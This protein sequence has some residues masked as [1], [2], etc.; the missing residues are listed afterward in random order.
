MVSKRERL[1][2]VG[3]VAQVL[4]VTVSAVRRWLLESKLIRVKLGRLV[5]IPESEIDRLIAEGMRPAKS[6][7]RGG[8]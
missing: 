5:R 2:S 7:K 1:L 6:I 4:G 8:A 3:E